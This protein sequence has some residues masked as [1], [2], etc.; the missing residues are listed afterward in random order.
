MPREIRSGRYTLE[1]ASYRGQPPGKEWGWLA[2]VR[3]SWNEGDALR[4]KG[5]VDAQARQEA[6]E[7]ALQLGLAWIREEG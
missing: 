6:D 2:E 1:A 4:L 5:I 3:I 7:I